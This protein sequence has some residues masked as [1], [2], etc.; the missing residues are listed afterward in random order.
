MILFFLFASGKLTLDSMLKKYFFELIS[1]SLGNR[2]ML[3]DVPTA[4]E[5]EALL[6]FA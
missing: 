4:A 5:W 6:S 2:E 1:I 3:S